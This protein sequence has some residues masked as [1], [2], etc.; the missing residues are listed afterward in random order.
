M[1]ADDVAL[2]IQ[3]LGRYEVQFAIRSGGHSPNPGFS[4]IGSDGIL[5]DLSAMSQVILSDDG[6]FASVGP[7]ARWGQ[8]S[9]TL[10]PLGATI[11]GAR[12]PHVGV[13]GLLLGGKILIF[14]F[15]RQETE[16]VHRR[17]FLCHI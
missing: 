13:G 5:F 3:I 4:S 2:M 16:R 17:L 12:E 11:V 8:V 14:Q 10:V 7:G 6:S 15:C 1:S 9:A